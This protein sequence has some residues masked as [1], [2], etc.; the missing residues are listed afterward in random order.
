MVPQMRT[1]KI[2]SEKKMNIFYD[3]KSSV[4]AVLTLLLI[5]IQILVDQSVV[6]VNFWS[7]N[8]IIYHLLKNLCCITGGKTKIVRYFFMFLYVDS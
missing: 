1:S 5:M 3:G 8:N 2:G 4:I 6:I 7:E